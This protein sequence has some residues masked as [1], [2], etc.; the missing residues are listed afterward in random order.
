V[1]NKFK[2]I[3][4]GR[5]ATFKQSWAVG[6]HFAKEL[7][8]SYPEITEKKLANLIKGSIYYYHKEKGNHLTHGM[9]Q[10]FL[11]RKQ[12]FPLYY[13]KFLKLY[14]SNNKK[15][16]AKDGGWIKKEKM[17]KD[18][19]LLLHYNEGKLTLSVISKLLKLKGTNGVYARLKKLEKEGNLVKW[20]GIG[21]HNGK[22]FIGDSGDI[23]EEYNNTEMTLGEIGKLHN[24]NDASVVQRL[25]KLEKEGN[26]V[27]WRKGKVKVE[28]TARN[29]LQ[30]ALEE[31]MLI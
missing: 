17:N 9:V 14:L 25:K 10:D 6:Y 12:K 30:D 5:P 8:D 21:S 27:K 20:R 26:L 16:T 1:S 19:S 28:P 31:D 15:E 3:D 18:E 23:L 11:G 4:E 13:Q 29:P 7:K 2:E 24:I 22:H